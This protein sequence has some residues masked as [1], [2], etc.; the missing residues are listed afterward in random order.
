VSSM[1]KGTTLSLAPSNSPLLS[2]PPSLNDLSDEDA[3]KVT[4]L[5]VQRNELTKL[6]ASLKRLK[7]LHL[8]DASFNGLTELPSEV[9]QL[10]HL[11]TVY[12]QS[13]ELPD[14]RRLANLKKLDIL[15]LEGNV[16]MGVKAKNVGRPFHEDRAGVLELVK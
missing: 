10:E 2:L 1:L 4:H 6:P 8:L 11:H 14:A 9:G 12:L 7:N 13:N 5:F 16:A 15:W 3:A